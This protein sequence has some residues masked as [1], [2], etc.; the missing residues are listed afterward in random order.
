MRKIS[1]TILAAFICTVWFGCAKEL[2]EKQDIS[3]K[4]T[5]K[6]SLQ[7][8]LVLKSGTNKNVGW[9]SQTGFR[10]A[11]TALQQAIVRNASAMN[12]KSSG[13]SFYSP[14]K[15]GCDMDGG[16]G[17]RH[18]NAIKVY[19]EWYLKNSVGKCVKTP[20]SIIKSMTSMFGSSKY[21]TNTKKMIVNQ[22]IERYNNWFV[23]SSSVMS[24]RIPVTE[25]ETLTFM[26]YKKQCFE[27]AN[28][29]AE[30]A[31]GKVRPYNSKAVS[32]TDYRPGMGLYHVNV[33]AMIITD[34]YWD[35]KGNPSKAK[36]AE[37]N[38]GKGWSNPGGQIAYERTVQVGAREVQ[39][40]GLK[41]VS[42]E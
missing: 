12:G 2:I 7:Y 24:I 25:G 18:R 11:E 30:N 34:I 28:S 21:S 32:K 14:S 13:T 38:Y 29:I 41:V 40:A 31:G 19:H 6:D 16:D 20:E 36:V 10:S 26:D 23:P 1:K 39:L 35:A 3:Q 27:W 8:G 5:S 22:I 17:K 33:H 37:S 15:W 4:V 9:A 42:F